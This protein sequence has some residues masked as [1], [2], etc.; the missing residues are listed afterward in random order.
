M[1]L[2]GCQ[3]YQPINAILNSWIFDGELI[4]RHS[5]FIISCDFSSK[6]EKL[7]RSKY[8]LRKAMLPSFIPQEVAKK[9]HTCTCMVHVVMYMYMKDKAGRMQA[10]SQ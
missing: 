2:I 1:I 5:E 8:T 6:P 10:C 7:W 3:V 9:V 4:D